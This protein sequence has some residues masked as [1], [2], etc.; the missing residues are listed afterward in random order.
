MLS[1]SSLLALALSFLPADEVDNLLEDVR[2][3]K[4]QGASS[5]RARAA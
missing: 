5:D 4:A 3:V 2:T 1:R